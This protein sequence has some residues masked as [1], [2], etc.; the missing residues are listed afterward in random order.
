MA[1]QDGFGEMFRAI[2]NAAYGSNQ[3]GG[4]SGK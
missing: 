2:N 3:R 4:G 1:F